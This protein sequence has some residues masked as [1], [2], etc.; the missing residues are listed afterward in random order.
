MSHR[1]VAAL[2]IAVSTIVMVAPQTIR[3]EDLVKQTQQLERQ[4]AEIQKQLAEIRVQQERDAKQTAE[5][6]QRQEQQAKDTEKKIG[7]AA[8][9]S[10]YELDNFRSRTLSLLDRVKVGGYGSVRY[11]YNSL[12]ELHNTFNF[13]RLVFTTEVNLAPRLRFYSELEFERF[14][15]LELERPALRIQDGGLRAQQAI[16]GTDG[17]EISL[18]QAWLQFDLFEHLSLRGGAVLVPVGRFNIHHDDNLW[19][20][21]RRPLVDRGVPVLPSTSAWDELGIGIVG[22]VPVGSKGLLDYQLYVVN[23][24][25]LAGE[26]ETIA[27]TRASD[28]TLLKTEVELS[29]QTGTFANDF[30]NSKAVT[31]RLAYSP[32]PGHEIAPSFYWGSYTPSFLPNRDLWSVAMDGLTTWGPIQLEGEYVFTRS[33]GLESVARSFAKTVINQESEGEVGNLESEVEFAL[34]RLASTKHGYWLEARYSFW[35]EWL[36]DT[37]LG[38]MFSN[39][40][41][42]PLARLEQV[43]IPSLVREASFSDG[44][45]TS[46]KTQSR[47]LNR[48]TGGIAYRPTPLVVFQLAY[49]YTRTNKDD[50]LSDVTNFLPAGP[51]DHDAHALLFGA[52]FGF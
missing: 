36:N 26:I 51:N 48:F 22:K 9:R 2:A 23:G 19:N 32:A 44:V 34:S 28:T 14:R 27:R 6:R 39:P 47:I 17:S 8:A 13:R 20:I 5:L 49:E 35:P 15:K 10:R 43:W 29:P 33:E 52:A 12:P 37:F 45:L 24:V 50:S 42:I 30:K 11:E 18:E 21:A 41:L 7:E 16:E 25:T 3:A 40:Q 38:H 31:G 4:L 46:F 1:M